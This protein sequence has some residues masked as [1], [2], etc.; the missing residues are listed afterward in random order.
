M[1][2]GFGIYRHDLT[3][4]TLRFARQAGATD[5]VVHLVDYFRQ[6]AGSERGDQPVGDAEGWGLAGGRDELWTV[7]MLSELKARI[8][9]HDLEWFSVENID[10]GHWHDILLDGPRRDE[11]IEDVKGLIRALGAVGIPVLGYNFSLAGVAGRTVGRF[12]RGGAEGV[13]MDG[14]LQTPIPAGMV[15]NM[16]FD[17]ARTGSLPRVERDE[18]WDRYRRFLADVLPVA[19]ECGVR[20]AAHPDD[21]PVPELRGQP[22]LLYR[23]TAFRTL[24]SLNESPAN[25]IDFCLGTVG[26]MPDDDLYEAV[27]EQTSAGRVA[28]VHFRNIRGKAPSYGETFVDEGDTDMLRIVDILKRNAFDGVLIPDH[29]P[30]MAGPSP[31]LTGMAFAMGYMTAALQSRGAL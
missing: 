15:W 3:D 1:R 31:W 28:Y 29:A 26:E 9:S 23:P 4:E 21:P 12:A 30:R 13:G 25:Q 14:V 20:L 2:L 27:D 7:E 5:I 24:V 11:Q 17:T 19:E 10:P 8:G 22:R 18:L 16:W 6:A